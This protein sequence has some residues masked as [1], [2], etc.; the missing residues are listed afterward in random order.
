MK[1]A[2]VVLVA[3]FL[4]PAL[5]ADAKMK[6]QRPT[7]RISAIAPVAG[8]PGSYRIPLDAVDPDGFVTELALD[9]GDGVVLQM[10]LFCDP[11]TGRPGEAVH[12]EITWSYAPGKY[13][14]HAQAT[15]TPRCFEGD[16]QNSKVDSEKLRV[17]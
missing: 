10:L 13:K 7:V 1:R 14:L 11:E 3:S 16:F 9:F 15:S 6:D 8:E 2:L 5:P 12:Q 17:R 4:I